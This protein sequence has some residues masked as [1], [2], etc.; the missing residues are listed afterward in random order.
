MHRGGELKIVLV[1]AEGF[2]C[3]KG[4]KSCDRKRGGAAGGFHIVFSFQSP[5]NLMGEEGEEQGG[6]GDRVGGC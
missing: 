5:K 3:R 4:K 6:A 1:I 2:R